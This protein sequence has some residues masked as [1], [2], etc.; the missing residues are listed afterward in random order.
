MTLKAPPLIVF[1][2]I[3]FPLTLPGVVIGQVLVFLNVMADFATVATDR[4]QQARAAAQPRAAVLRRLADPRRLGRGRAADDLHADRRGDRRHARGRHP[5]ARSRPM[6][7]RLEAALAPDRLGAGHADRHLPRLSMAADLHPRPAVLR[8]PDRRHHLPDE[9]RLVP[10]VRGAVEGD[11]DERLQAAA[12]ALL[13]AGGW[14]ARSR[15]SCCRSW[16]R[17]RCAGSSAA[18][19]GSST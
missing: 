4:R 12:A 14:P 13:A 19:A 18:T 16:R 5:P 8:R 11:G 9:R 3:V 2:R 7:T 17:R 6:K 1:W 10:L 15:P